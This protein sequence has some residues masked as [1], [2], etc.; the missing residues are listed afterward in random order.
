VPEKN[1]RNVVFGEFL[2]ACAAK[3]IRRRLLR[4]MFTRDNNNTSTR[5]HVDHVSFNKTHAPAARPRHEYSARTTRAV[6]RVWR[7][8]VFPP[9]APANG[10]PRVIKR[11]APVPA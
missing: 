6:I 9:S 11:F 1:H 7:P 4:V 10:F 3:N 8:F 2:L 5:G